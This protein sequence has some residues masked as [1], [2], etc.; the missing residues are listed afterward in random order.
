ME[1]PL[2][3]IIGL[4][5]GS[6]VNVVSLRYQPGGKLFGKK[7]IGVKKDDRSHCLKCGKTL[8]WYEL[9]PVLSFL[10]QYGKC[11]HCGHRLSFQYPLVEI[12][13]GIIFTAVPFNVF[14]NFQLFSQLSDYKLLIS[15]IWIVIFLL[16][17]LLSIIDFRHF[18]IPDQINLSLAI[19]GILLIG[20]NLIGSQQ[21][22]IGH[23][24]LLFG[25]IG[26]VWLN[27]LFAALIG[28]VFFGLII[29][30]SK[31][32][33]MGWG[34]F[35][36][37]GPLGLIFGWPDVLIIIALSFI[38]GSIIGISLVIKKK[39]TIKE[40]VPFGPFLVAGSALV[41][42]FGYQIVNGYFKIFGL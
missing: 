18:I 1:Y 11:R 24:A 29:V 17:L 25:L 14:K 19:L 20:V 31:G 21:F 8:N 27:H 41:F 15:A 33:A 5:V 28:M 2:L 3:F 35:K 10:I 32:R 13:S 7:I 42:F 37:I 34:D 40:A 16:L 36:L 38:V 23:Y 22:F 4:M 12:L 26:N 30:L 6:F 39:K 9:I